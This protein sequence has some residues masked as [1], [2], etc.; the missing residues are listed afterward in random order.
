MLEYENPQRFVETY[1]AE[2]A[3]GDPRQRVAIG[4]GN[5]HT[6]VH[7]S[8]MPRRLRIVQMAPRLGLGRRLGGGLKRMA[9]VE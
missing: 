9:E 6:R 5:S 1:T 7:T 2:V 8:S 3:L 4:R